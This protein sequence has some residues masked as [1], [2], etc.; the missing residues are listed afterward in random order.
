M[1]LYGEHIRCWK[2]VFGEIPKDANGRSY[3]IH[4]IDGN[5]NNNDISNLQCVTI[6]EHYKIHLERGE[7]GAAF[8][9]AGRMSKRPEDIAEIARKGTLERI[10][11]GTHN[12]LDP[13]F[14]RSMDHNIGYVVAIDTRTND[15]CRITKED[16]DAYDYYVGANTN[17]KMKSIHTNRGHNKG[18][19]WKQS[20]KRQNI[21]VC[22]HCN[23]SGDASGLRRWHFDNCKQRIE[24]E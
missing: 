2:K 3:E 12:F 10:R 8:L 18:K 19:R 14:P 6:D 7:F 13:N 21:V 24:N 17:R 20:T 16:F 5:P 1:T 22:P 23:K 15:V 4:H 11:N 9:I